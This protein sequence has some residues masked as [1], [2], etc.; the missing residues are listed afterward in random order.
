MPALVQIC[1][2]IVT[3]GLLAI[4]LMTVRMMSRVNQAAEDLSQ[5]GHAI[6]ESAARFDLVAHEA[7]ALVASL[8]ECIPPVQR[9]V[10]RCDTV[11]ERAADLSSAILEEVAGPVFTA[12][13]VA[14][15]VRSGAGHFLQRMVGRWIDRHSPGDGGHDHERKSG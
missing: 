9:V 1:I 14:R 3:I 6:R 10:G 2:V 7:R 8:R 12:A 11:S 15:G 4:A 5:V 13:A